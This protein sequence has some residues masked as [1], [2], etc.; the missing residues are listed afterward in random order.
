MEQGWSLY[1]RGKVLGKGSFGAAILVTRKKDGKQFVIK[2][3]DISR[4][5]PAEKVA[6][7][8]EAQLLMAL[9]HPNIVRCYDT[10]TEANKMCIV[11]EL[12]SEGDL[13]GILNKKKGQ[14]LPEETILDWFVQMCLG[15]K[16]VHDRK[17]L[18]RDIKTQN[19][20]VSSGGILK[21]GDFGVSKIL[22]STWQMAGT[23]VGTPYYLSP[24]ICQNKKYNQKSDVWSLGCVLYELAT[25][26]H[27]F[28]APNMRALIQKIVTG[29]YNPLP[30]AR[31]KDLRDLIARMLVIDQSKRASI[32]DL[33]QTPFVKAR[34]QKFLSATL[35]NNEFSHTIIHG[36]P[37]P[38]QL[39]VGA[40]AAQ[41]A[42][43]AAAAGALGAK[44]PAPGIGYASPARAG[45]APAPGFGSPAAPGARPSP[46]GIPAKGP[47]PVRGP[48][49]VPAAKGPSPVRGPSPPSGASRAQA[50]A[51]AAAKLRAESEAR[52]ARRREQERRAAAAASEDA[53]RARDAD[54]RAR[55]DASRRRATEEASR[56]REAER[57]AAKKQVDAQKAEY[58]ERQQAAARNRAAAE[59]RPPV[60][61]RPRKQW[62]D[63]D[64]PEDKNDNGNGAGG[65]YAA[66]AA[67]AAGGAGGAG[68][69]G[70][71]RGGGKE[72][73]ELS[74]EQ[75]RAV[76]D[77]QQAAAHR[78]RRQAQDD[79]A[80]G[81]AGAG[82]LA[83]FLGVPTDDGDDHSGARGAAGPPQP[84]RASGSPAPSS[85]LSER[86]R[87]CKFEGGFTAGPPPQPARASGS[88]APNSALSERERREVYNENKAA[89]A[90]NRRNAADADRLPPVGGGGGAAAA[91]VGG[92]YAASEVY[93]RRRERL[94]AERA[95]REAE[96]REFQQ[97]HYK[98]MKEAALR[99]R[100][101]IR[102][103][104]R[105]GGGGQAAGAGE[106][107]NGHG[108]ARA[109][110]DADG[111]GD[112]FAAMVKDM[113]DLMTDS[114]GA[115]V[116]SCN[117][118]DAEE[119][120]AGVLAGRFLLNGEVVPL[121]V[122]DD[123]ALG[124]RMEAL[125]AFLE[126]KL[127]S[128]PFLK[129]YRRLEGLTADDDESE[130]SK[131]FLGV[132][133]ADKLPYLQLVHQLIVC[134]E[135][136]EGESHK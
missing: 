30:S 100:A 131:E 77:E 50:E 17:I 28:E 26:Q 70:G 42:S 49:P 126:D 63:P 51:A 3:I 123:D 79:A 36:R 5:P 80:G 19:V 72:G 116:A 22:A 56:R 59:D 104:I 109:V 102:A 29:R 18:H 15:L 105:P 124:V 128:G 4:M 68:G 85:A 16:H 13:Y 57:A 35:H 111:D 82:G 71:G 125:R 89:V 83:A 114:L 40:A 7:K 81:V 61:S 44:P 66:Y 96:I 37:Q 47:S 21:L 27:A 23:S 133:G 135:Q 136:W 118:V 76:W 52:D 65:G 69:G 62:V 1:V 110:C 112:D 45:A 53:R 34:I 106:A 98:E 134:E 90:R 55:E 73:V 101:A 87:T 39:V 41:A 67:Y 58:I 91:G 94:E 46:G 127:G 14:Q 115:G 108:Q 95:K 103:D 84:A 32:N 48:S 74:A 122:C 2:E 93:E 6:S 9:N 129:V 24:E 31:S 121:P 86:E 20:F 54:A 119:E 97:Q 12:C 8:Q 64:L 43:L 60:Q 10:F 107:P 120:L 132:L 88:L 75:R 130:V 78:N 11:M 99:N 33:L 25:Q 38:G 117:D 113:A 92:G